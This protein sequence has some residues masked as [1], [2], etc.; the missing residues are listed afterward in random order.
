MEYASGTSLR[1]ARVPF[2]RLMNCGWMGAAFLIVLSAPISG[3]ASLSVD[4]YSTQNVTGSLN[5]GDE[6]SDV[7]NFATLGKWV[8]APGSL[9]CP[10]GLGGGWS[11]AQG[12]CFRSNIWIT[13]WVMFEVPG[14][15]AKPTFNLEVQVGT[16]CVVQG[17]VD[18]CQQGVGVEVWSAPSC[19]SS[20][21][22]RR[23]FETVAAPAAHRVSTYNRASDACIVVARDGAGN[24]RPSLRVYALDFSEALIVKDGPGFS[25]NI[26]DL[27]RLGRGETDAPAVLRGWTTPTNCP[28]GWT[29]DQGGC[30]LGPSTWMTGW[31]MF[32][33]PASSPSQYFTIEAE[34][35]TQCTSPYCGVPVSMLVF[36]AS[37]CQSSSWT[38]RG[39]ASVTEKCEIHR[40]FRGSTSTDCIL[41]GRGGQGNA[42]RNIRLNR[43]EMTF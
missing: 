17:G 28:P 23:G 34:T 10:G 36:S 21:W 4:E 40:F 14:T 6:D 31:S 25:F 9:D 19:G 35:D 3:Y 43:V 41:I 7:T 33:V 26:Q 16:D 18:Y 12:G 38:S 42:A 8:A 39:T 13:G 32:E 20:S 5:V 1:K 15:I 24:L 11:A 22:T 29:A 2:S 27:E 37:S 30:R